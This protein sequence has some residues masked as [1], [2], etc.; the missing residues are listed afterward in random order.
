MHVRSN[1]KVYIIESDQYLAGGIRD[2]LELDDHQIMGIAASWQAAHAD[3]KKHKPTV[4]IFDLYTVLRDVPMA[5]LRQTMQ[6]LSPKAALITFGRA[7]EMNGLLR[8]QI[9]AKLIKPFDGEELLEVVE[10]VSAKPFKLFE[11][12]DF[13]IFLACH[14][15]K[16]KLLEALYHRQGYRIVGKADDSLLALQQI[17]YTTPHIIVTQ[18]YMPSMSG[19]QLIGKLQ[20][21]YPSALTIALAP[22]KHHIQKFNVAGAS[23]ILIHPYLPRDLLKI[24]HQLIVDH[25]ITPENT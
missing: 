4:I 18:A 3:I 20:T 15:T 14:E 24:T 13:G 16:H 12:S 10:Q 7:M 23:A 22:D 21:V 25:I 19:A 9:D 5:D 11:P 6:T 17:P 1:K 8:N 2:V